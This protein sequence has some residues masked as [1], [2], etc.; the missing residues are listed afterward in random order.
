M[1]SLPRLKEVDAELNKGKLEQQVKRAGG[2]TRRRCD[3]TCLSPNAH[4][5]RIT[6]SVVMPTEG[7]ISTMMPTARVQARPTCG[8]AAA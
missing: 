4:A 5:S 3:A 7:L 2:S 1:G 8:D 6:T